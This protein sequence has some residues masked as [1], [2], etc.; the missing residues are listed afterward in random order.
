MAI[1]EGMGLVGSVTCGKKHKQV[2]VMMIYSSPKHKGVIG[3]TVTN[4]LYSISIIEQQEE[5]KLESQR[6]PNK[7]NKF[8]E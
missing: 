2:V 1:Y 5:S 3:L 8:S 7:F 6:Q 4:Q